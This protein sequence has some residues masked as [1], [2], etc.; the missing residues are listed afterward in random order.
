MTRPVNAV[1][2]VQRAQATLL[3][4]SPVRAPGGGRER[5]VSRGEGGPRVSSREPSARAPG[6]AR[7]RVGVLPSGPPTP[8]L[9]SVSP[10]GALIH[11]VYSPPPNVKRAYWAGGVGTR[12]GPW[13]SAHVLSPREKEAG[14]PHTVSG[15]QVALWWAHRQRK[16]ARL[17][18]VVVDEGSPTPPPQV[19]V[20]GG[21]LLHLNVRHR[22]PCPC[23]STDSRQASASLAKCRDDHTP[24]RL[25]I[26][27]RTWPGATAT[28]KRRPR[29]ASRCIATGS[30]MAAA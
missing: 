11:P 13:Y 2:Y 20:P 7:V 14:R 21:L 8:R 3:Q 5:V 25:Q 6:R 27:W 22:G 16:M 30:S 29:A 10:R 26:R 15:R 18:V 9:L 12:A 17:R 19:K 4:A 1:S 24:H 28:S 23:A